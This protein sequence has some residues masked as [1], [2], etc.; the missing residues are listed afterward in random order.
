MNEESRQRAASGLTAG[1]RLDLLQP[2]NRAGLEAYAAVWGA[3]VPREPVT[4]E[5]IIRAGAR[6]AGDDVRLLARREWHVAGCA[7]IVRSDLPGR[8]FVRIAVLPDHRRHGIGTAFLDVAVAEARRQRSAFL[9]TA[10][11]EGDSAGEAFAAHFGFEEAFRE[12]EVVRRLRPDESPPP[13]PAGIEIVPVASRPGLVEG[14]YAIACIALPEM[15]LPAPYSVPPVEH[16]AEE[17]AVG[18]GVL[19]GGTFAAVENGT[20]VGFAGLL[21]RGADPRV[22]EHGLAAVAPEAR[23]RGI[24]TALKQAQI[25]WAAANGYRELVTYTQAGNHAM[26]AVNRHLGYEPRPAWMRLEAPV[27]VVESRLAGR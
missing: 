9:S 20:V 3:V 23:R 13:P 15:P 7:G 14:A 16:W 11:E 2:D 21:R 26:Q 10:V 25:A 18:P 8:T 1:I 19:H 22:A 5:E 6:R 27:S 12:V 4:P 17:D 24:A